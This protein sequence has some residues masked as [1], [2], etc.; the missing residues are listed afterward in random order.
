MKIGVQSNHHRMPFPAQFENLGVLGT[1]KPKFADMF[2]H[3][4]RLP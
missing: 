1:R 4:S 3:Q 2:T